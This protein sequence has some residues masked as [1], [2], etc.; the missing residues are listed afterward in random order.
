MK[1]FNLILLLFFVLSCSDND[2]T[3]QLLETH[4]NLHLNQAYD[5]KDHGKYDSAFIAFDKA[6]DYFIEQGDSVQAGNC[7]VNMAILLTNQGD[8]YGGQETALEALA[9]FN[10]SDTT[11]AIYLAANYNNLGIATY[12]LKDYDHAIRFYDLA[13]TYSIDSLNTLTYLNNKARV[14]HNKKEFDKAIAIYEAILERSDRQSRNY[15][16]LLTNLALAR[17]RKNPDYNALHEFTQALHIRQKNND[18]S[19][20]NSSYMHLSDY[21]EYS[22]TDSA[23]FYTRKFYETSLMI[24]NSDDQIRALYRLIRLSPPDSAKQYFEAYKTLSDSLQEARAAAK[25]QFALIRYEV[26]KNKADNLRLQKENAEKAY[27]VTRQR[28]WTGAAIA[29]AFAV[30][31]GGIFWYRKREQRL[32]L[33]AQNRIKAHQLKT[34]KKIHDVVANGLYRVMAEIENKN[35]IDREGILDRL[36]DMYEQSRDISY[37]NE[38]LV[39]AE[40]PYHEQISTLLKSFAAE[41]VKVIIAGNDPEQW[42]GIGSTICKETKHVLQELMVNMRKHSGATNVV[43]RFDRDS[44]Q[45]SIYYSDNGRGL[46][47]AFQRGNGLTNTGN[48]IERLGGEIIFASETGKGLKITITIPV[49]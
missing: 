41:S 33:E 21:Y 9:F 48:R 28:V 10:P 46:P 17:W 39:P 34:S 15:A 2:N 5:F 47:E 30:V 35:D 19:G 37:E 40:Q 8:Y 38:E 23:I 32:T 43:V 11:H 31:G 16:R 44:S 49:S 13:I 27:Q 29:L 25:N 18:L 4:D 24:K 14:Y 6:K 7:L 22:R 12:S 3:K 45:F 36:E 20:L 26:E 42:S 1:N